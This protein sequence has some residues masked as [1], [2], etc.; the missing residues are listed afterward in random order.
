MGLSMNM[1]PRF[2]SGGAILSSRNGINRL[3]ASSRFLVLLVVVDFG[4]LGIDDVFFFLAVGYATGTTGIIA[5]ARLLLA[6]LLV[7]R[8]AELHR[9]LLQ[10][11][12]LGR[13]R[14]RIGSLQGFLEVGHRVFDGAALGLADLRAVLGERFLS[15]MDERLGVVL[16]LDL[17]LAL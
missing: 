7:H 9:S 5:A 12:S 10:C 14:L 4:E 11:I 3:A 1:H 16:R 15:H 2:G 8:F 6:G 13:D 17:S